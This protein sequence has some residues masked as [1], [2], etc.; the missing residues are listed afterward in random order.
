M[1]LLISAL[2]PIR[3][4]HPNLPLTRLPLGLLTLIFRLRRKL[5]KTM[6]KLQDLCLLAV[7]LEDVWM[8]RSLS[9]ALCVNLHGMRTIRT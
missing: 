4:I 6:A 2:R 8:G 9:R 3:L 1:E 5:Y 7:R